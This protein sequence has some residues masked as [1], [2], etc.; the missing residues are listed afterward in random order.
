MT[1]PRI[2][3]WARTHVTSSTRVQPGDVVS[4]E[5][6]VSARLLLAATYRDTLRAG[7]LPTV[8]P[9]L[10]ELNAELLNYGSN[11]Q[12]VW[13]SVEEKIGGTVHMALGAAYPETG[14]MQAS[15]IHWDLICDLRVGGS[16][17]VDGQPFLVDGRYVV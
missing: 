17:H 1:H 9:R 14:S 8:M 10:G 6:D 3:A 5:G 16:V 11:E 4:I 7:G 13:L 15:A 12:L 2:E